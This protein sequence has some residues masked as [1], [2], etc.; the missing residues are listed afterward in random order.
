MSGERLVRPCGK[1]GGAG[2]LRCYSHIAGGL[3]FRCE[4]TGVRSCSLRSARSARGIV[5]KGQGGRPVP[6]ALAL[7][8]VGAA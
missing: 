7:V 5:G 2:R 8:P 6:R 4:G 1:C 3:C